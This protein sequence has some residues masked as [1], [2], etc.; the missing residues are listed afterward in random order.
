MAIVKDLGVVTAY[1]Y[2]VQGG[3][4]GTEAEFT[5]ML[6]QAGVT[7][8]QLENLTAVATTLS[9]GSEATA[10]YSEGVLTFGIP[11]GNTGATGPQGPQ[12]V[13]GETG[14]GISSITKTATAGLVD[15]YT[16]TFTDGATTTFTVTNGADGD[17]INVAAAFDATK[18]YA[19]GDMVLYQGTL[20]AFTA[21]HAAGAWVGTDA[22]AVILADQVTELK[23]D[24]NYRV[25]ET[26]ITYTFVRPYYW[27]V[28]TETAVNT[29]LTGSNWVAGY[30]IPVNAGEKYRIKA[31][32]GN[33]NKTR[34]WI[35]A[36]DDNNIIQMAN[37][38]Y[39]T[40]YHEETVVAPEGATRLLITST[41]SAVGAVE[42]YAWCYKISAKIGEWPLEGKLLS[43]L[44]DSI[45]AYTG[46]IPEGNT[47]YYTGSNSGVTSPDQMWWKILCNETG[48]TPCVINGWSGSGINWQTDSVHENIVPMSDDSRCSALN[49]GTNTPDIIL[50]AGG[51]N[52]Y[53][54]AEY[55]QNEPLEWNGQ[56]IPEYTEPTAGKKVYA[57]FTEAYVAMIKKIQTNYP[58]AIVIALSTWFTM[59]G[60]DNGYV[61]T[62]SVGQNIYTQQNYNDKI[63][64]VA[65]QMHI[66]YIDV[67]NIGFNRNN[68]YPTY[69]SDS[70]TIPTHPN[71]AGHAVMGKA[72]A[73]KIM[74]L[75]TGYMH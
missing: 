6:G 35:F 11:R 21:A 46:T 14:N 58:N 59:R 48:M 34:I 18:A 70:S 32:Q 26:E 53:T 61:L 38:Y 9:E 19:V 73:K 42:P 37:N 74:N 41:S 52:D 40:D 47:P 66:P 51:L 10:S 22:Q 63:K 27:N 13:Q 60:T 45:S 56:S 7:L 30:P 69:A 57:S 12:G 25:S 17:I 54:Y 1:A 28:E 44:G 16:I 36:D 33:T 2:A 5:E 62:H 3:Y 68:F 20:Y 43:L 50:I 49:D 39:G 72:I 71:A 65:E 15:T 31:C 64:Y 55:A 29:K 8:E 75:V 23:D 67:S 24:L 4:E